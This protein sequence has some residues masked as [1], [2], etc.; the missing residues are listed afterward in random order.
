MTSSDSQ[1]A[2]RCPQSPVKVTS[3]DFVSLASSLVGHAHHGL[4][5][6]LLVQPAHDLPHVEPLRHVTLQPEGEAAHAIFFWK[7][8]L[9]RQ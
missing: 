4:A 5:R 6:Q 7:T 8:P 9:V 1:A 2:A 3:A